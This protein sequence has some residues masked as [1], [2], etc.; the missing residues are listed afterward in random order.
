MMVLHFE[1]E[2]GDWLPQRSVAIDNP[3]MDQP[4]TG[5]ASSATHK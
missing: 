3:L 2:P 4:A 1:L 5:K